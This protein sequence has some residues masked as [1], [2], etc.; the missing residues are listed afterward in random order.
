MS[1]ASA[2]RL[3]SHAGGMGRDDELAWPAGQTPAAL[4]LDAWWIIF[5]IVTSFG[6]SFLGIYNIER[7]FWFPADLAILLVFL[8]RPA[9]F[10][11][12]MRRNLLLVSWPLLA[13]VSFLWSLAPG[14]SL[15]HGIQF[16]MTVMIGFLWSMH[17]SV[18][19]LMQLLFTALLICAIL[20]VIGVTVLPA[21]FIYIGGGW[22]G[23]FPHKNVLGQM[24]T[25]LAFTSVCLF[26]YGWRPLVSGL[27]TILAVGLVVM[28]KSATSLTVLVVLLSAFPVMLAFR[29]GITL[30]TA[31]VGIL[32]MAAA[33]ALFLVE[34]SNIDLFRAYLE[35]MD[36][37][38]TLTGRTVLWDLGVEAFYNHPWVGH[39]FKGYWQSGETSVAWL[40]F[41]MQ[42]DLWFFH[43]N[44]LE[45]AVAF[46]IVGPMVMIAGI[47][48]GLISV[49]RN[50]VVN[51]NPMTFWSVLLVCFVVIYCFVDLVLFVNHTMTQVLFVATV[52]LARKASQPQ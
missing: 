40:R 28:S 35:A 42:Q 30:F 50:V 19:R 10:F 25:I 49:T 48:G 20:S 5:I 45:V 26:L 38:E 7:Y 16:L 21:R 13:C 47:V 39:G 37:E 43:N 15:Y 44:F 41:V 52:A 12:V 9:P 31:T 4:L 24:M 6:A 51:P 3:T 46:G 11:D 34:E 33:V 17:W 8:A 22:M 2:L 36:K 23:V 32:L 1:E 27:G 29:R 18:L 14:M